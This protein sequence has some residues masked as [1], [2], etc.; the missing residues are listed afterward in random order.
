MTPPAARLAEVLF[1]AAWDAGYRM[2]LSSDRWVGIAQQLIDAGLVASDPD[3]VALGV[4]DPKAPTNACDEK[5]AGEFARP[6]R[7]LG[8]AV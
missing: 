8:G 2:S 6:V 5:V 7:S 3:G 1:H 4:I